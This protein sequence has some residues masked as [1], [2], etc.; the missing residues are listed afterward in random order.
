MALARGA[1]LASANAPLFASSTAA[2]A[3]ALDPGTGEMSPR[4]LSPTYLDVWGNADLGA[5]A[6][7]YSA[8]EDEMTKP[9]AG[10]GPSWWP[11]VRWRGSSPSWPRCCWFR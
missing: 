4:A 6:L 2:L 10:A 8:I 11:V 3:Y 1:A 5:G 7:A 9:R